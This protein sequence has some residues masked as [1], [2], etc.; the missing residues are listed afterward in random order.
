M[1]AI[2]RSETF[3]CFEREFDGKMPGNV[4]DQKIFL[5]LFSLIVSG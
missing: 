1:D 2:R 3:K 4:G 5:S